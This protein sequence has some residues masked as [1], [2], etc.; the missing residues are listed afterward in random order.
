[1]LDILDRIYFVEELCGN[2]FTV[3]K[4]CQTKRTGYN[5]ALLPCKGQNLWEYYVQV[6][7]AFT[8]IRPK[9]CI[10]FSRLNQFVE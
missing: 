5:I 2:L 3:R 4:R 7:I 8:L 6:K 9:H 1:M 10:C